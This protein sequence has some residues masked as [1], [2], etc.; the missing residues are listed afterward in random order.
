MSDTRLRSPAWSAGSPGRHHRLRVR[1]LI[2]ITLPLTLFYF[3][4]LL[5]PDRIGNPVMYAILVAAEVFNVVQALGFWWTCQAERSRKPLALPGDPPTVDVFIPVYDEPVSVVGP[6]VVAATHLRGAIV[7]VYLLDDGKNPDMARLA[8]RFGAGYITR[9][10]NKGAKAG[11][12]NHALGKTNG[13]FVLVLDCDHVPDQRFLQATLGYTSDERVAFVQTP[14]YYANAAEGDVQAAAW[15]QQ[16]LFFGAIARGKDG[17]GSMFCCGTNV[18]FRRSALLDVGGFPEDSVTEDFQLSIR[19]H[20]RGWRT[21]YVPEVLASGL[22]PEDMSSYVSQQQRW[23]RGCLSALPTALRARLPFRQKVQYALSASF[24]L[25]GWTVLIYMSFPILRILTGEQPLAGTS[26]DQ[27]LLHFGPYFG[28]ALYTVALL[29]GGTYSFRAFALQS[30]S[31]WIHIQASLRTLLR[32]PGRFV[33]TPKQGALV[34]QPRAVVPA[35]LMIAVLVGVAVYGLTRDRSPAT[36]NN[37]AFA[38][39]HITV[40]ATGVGPALRVARRRTEAERPPTHTRERAPGRRTRE[41][42]PA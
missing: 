15:A 1:L 26:A 11:N 12:I 5:Q 10:D 21:A 40:L 6:T 4:W 24:F 30:A 25:S 29:G 38:A 13:E 17:Q 14:Q 39:L 23:A 27:F 8:R 34:R 18:V 9:P 31:F 16:A 28:F 35:L 20:E 22:G 3:T 33:V 36:L 41:R 32:R 42:V 19:L 7:R 37:V 2:V